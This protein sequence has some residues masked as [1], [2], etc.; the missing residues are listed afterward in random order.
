MVNEKPI[1][2][3]DE[4]VGLLGYF[5]D[6]TQEGREQHYLETLAYTDSLTGL[7]NRRAFVRTI[8]RYED[9]YERNR[10]DFSLLF[11]DI[12]G[13]KKYN[14]TY[15]HSFGDEVLRRVAACIRRVTGYTGVACRIGGDE[16]VIIHQDRNQNYI[17]DAENKLH[18]AVA[19]IEFIQKRPCKLDLAMGRAVYSE[20]NDREELLRFADQRMYLNKQKRR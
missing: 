13:F 15:G 8:A 1:Y 7:Y 6:I 9:E 20:V 16:F 2:V 3:E 5:K 12:N 19:E 14:D 11:I 17:K 18:Q 10:I 4:I